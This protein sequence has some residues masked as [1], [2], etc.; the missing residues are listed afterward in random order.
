MRRTRF[1]EWPCPIAR[2]ADLLGDWWTPL[3][4]RQAFRG[5]RRF[6]EIQRSLDIPK[7]VLAARLERLVAE[8]LLLKV[9]Y[10][11][12]PVRH[13]YRLTPKG[14]ATW[15]VLAAMWRWGSDWAFD[16]EPPVVLADRETD[17]EVVPLV[18]DERTGDPLDVRR[19]RM[20]RNP[21]AALPAPG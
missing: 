5:E 14:R 17:E 7:A 21:R 2:T 4:L 16:G 10:Q 13:E 6:D 9:A 20:R 11:E 8:G 3:V 18:V 15:D 1:D 12:H 19:L